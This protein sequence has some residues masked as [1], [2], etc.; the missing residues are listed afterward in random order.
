MQTVTKKCIDCPTEFTVSVHACNKV[1]CDACQKEVRL[2]YFRKWQKQKYD[3]QV[4]EKK[5]RPY[6]QT[7]KVGEYATMWSREHW[8]F[9]GNRLPF[10]EIR[11][12][13]HE[14]YISEMR[15]EHKGRMFEVKGNSLVEV[16]A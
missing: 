2:A 8:E 13:V 12:M 3:S 1:R 10:G 5:P 9:N 6:V 16:A 4:H 7:R 11:S 14:G 15:V